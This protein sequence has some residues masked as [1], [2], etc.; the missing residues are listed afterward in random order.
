VPESTTEVSVPVK[1]LAGL[2]PFVLLALI[3]WLL[4][5]RPQRR[6]QQQLSKTQ[7]TLGPGT[8]VMLGSGIFGT[9]SSV[10]DDRIHLQ[11]APGTVVTVARQAVVRVVDSPDHEVGPEAG[12][13][14]VTGSGT[15]TPEAAPEP[16]R[17][18]DTG[19]DEQHQ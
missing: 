11:I 18:G 16:P 14:P 19:T 5:I 7:Q 6:R 9:V 12:T 3:F 2:L 10:E 13:G 17:T 8:E 1:D 4:I 15:A